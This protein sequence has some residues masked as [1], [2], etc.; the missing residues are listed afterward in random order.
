[1]IHT[2]QSN[3]RGDLRAAVKDLLDPR[4][5]ALLYE[6]LRTLPTRIAKEGNARMNC[7]NILHPPSSPIEHEILPVEESSRAKVNESISAVIAEE[8]DGYLENNKTNAK[9]S[10]DLQQADVHI[11]DIQSSKIGGVS[12]QSIGLVVNTEDD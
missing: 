4:L 9:Q 12:V 8:D 3:M 1:M 5:I 6:R 10:I 2:L 7:N 11:S